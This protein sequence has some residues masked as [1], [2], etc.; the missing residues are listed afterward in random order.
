MSFTS[1]RAY[2]LANAIK[3]S[4]NY[5]AFTRKISKLRSELGDRSGVSQINPTFIVLDLNKVHLYKPLLEKRSKKIQEVIG[6]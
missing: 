3:D 2:Y 6:K 1:I 5:C 4:C